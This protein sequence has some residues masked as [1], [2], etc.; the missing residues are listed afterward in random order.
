[1]SSLT[2]SRSGL[3]FCLIALSAIA[4]PAQRLV[5]GSKPTEEKAGQFSGAFCSNLTGGLRLC[6]V[7]TSAEGDA[8]FI[9]L[10]G[11]T[12]V[13]RVEAP[14]WTTVNISPDGFFAYRGD[15]DKDGT[16]EVVLVS[17]EGVSQG[18]G[19]TYSTVYIFNGAAGSQGRPISFPIQE[20][21][22]KESFIYDPRN[23]RTEILISYWADYDSIEPKR[24]MGLYLTGK[25][26]RY[27]RGKLKPVLEKPTLARR[28]LN[29]FAAERDNGWFENRKPFTWLKDR[30]THKL[31]R[32]PDELTKPTAVRT[33]TIKAFEAGENAVIHFET[34][35][36][37]ALKGVFGSA[38]S[39]DQERK[40]LEISSVGL[41]N[42]RYVYPMSYSMNFDPALYFDRFEG[43][44]VRIETYRTEYGDEYAKVWL[45]DE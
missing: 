27:D 26:F 10:K 18:M 7:K 1:M 36:G 43:R 30:R 9:V 45:L 21:G 12:T 35:S 8:D 23:R 24:A 14:A 25:W 39:G 16:Q 28:F 13:S 38:S 32:E 34:E 42:K 22:E 19:V 40:P 5:Q 11:S 17:L 37:E 44:R 3:L 41:W 20:F 15:L 33:G 4:V 6:K 2:I 29:S 31:F